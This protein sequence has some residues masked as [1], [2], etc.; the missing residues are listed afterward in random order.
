MVRRRNVLTAVKGGG[1]SV[2][3][4]EASRLQMA[5]AMVD[6]ETPPAAL[7]AL[8]RELRMTQA[9]IDAVAGR[10]TEGDEIDELTARREARLSG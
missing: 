6:P 7:A 1:V 5:K 2:E 9:A 4:L 10:V 8:A 3:V